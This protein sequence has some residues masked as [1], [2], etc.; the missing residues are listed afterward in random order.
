MDKDN[1]NWKHVWAG[2][3]IVV[4]SGVI[5]NPFSNPW[6]S[7]PVG[8][9]LGI[10]AGF[11]KEFIWDKALGKGVFNWQDI[12]AISWGSFVGLV[13]LIFIVNFCF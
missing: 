9:L 6:I 8:F 11:S 5:I 3:L 10:V 13:I 7:C 1:S 12:I 2:I 4:I